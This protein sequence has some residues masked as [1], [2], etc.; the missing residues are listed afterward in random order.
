MNNDHLLKGQKAEDLAEAFLQAQGLI[1]LVKN[2]SCKSGEIDLIMKEK[3][4]VVFV[5]VRLRTNPFFTHAAES[6]NYNKQ[7]KLINTARFYLQQTGLFD[8]VA[9]RFD[10]IAMNNNQRIT[11]TDWIK[12][13]FGA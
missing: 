9:C 8:K 3:E 5:E 10:V 7:R 6:V 4:V 11:A 2:F 13:A 1:S 12:N